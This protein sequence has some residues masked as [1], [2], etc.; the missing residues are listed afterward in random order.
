MGK[1]RV[2]WKKAV[3]RE[4]IKKE[5]RRRQGSKQ[6]RKGKVITSKCSSLERK[7]SFIKEF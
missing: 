4:Q 7:F 5:G 3:R 2:G 1:R 6:G